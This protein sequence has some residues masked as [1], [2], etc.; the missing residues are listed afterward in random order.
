MAHQS[1]NS[2]AF[3]DIIR[4]LIEL[5]VDGQTITHVVDYAGRDRW[6][7]VREATRADALSVRPAVMSLASELSDH[8]DRIRGINVMMIGLRETLGEE[9]SILGAHQICI[10][11]AAHAQRLRA[12]YDDVLVD[13]GMR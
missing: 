4:Q 13:L 3:T 12:L 8:Q 6:R 10:D 7:A 5:G 11:L 2:I 1:D 9:S